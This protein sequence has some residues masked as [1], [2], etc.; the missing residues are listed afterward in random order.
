MCAA[1]GNGRVGV[2]LSPVTQFNDI[3]EANPQETFDYVVGELK[4][5]NL[6]FLDILQGTGGAPQDQW[7]PFNYARLRALYKGNLILNN[8]YDF[9]SGQAAV[10]GGAADASPTAARCSPTPIW[11]SASA[12]APRSTSPTTRSSTSARKR[13]TP[14]IPS[15]RRK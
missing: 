3:S 1:I 4:R 7:L 12:A 6:A 10:H 9:A 5:Y 8:G 2:R 13:A 11:S 15:C 14:T